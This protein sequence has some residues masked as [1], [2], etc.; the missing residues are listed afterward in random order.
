MNDKCVFQNREEYLKWCERIVMKIYYAKIAMNN[1]NIKDAIDEI[2]R[3]LW[4]REGEE[5]WGP[6]EKT[7]SREPG[8]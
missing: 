4:I 3:S 5:L 7:K 8:W 2:G 1:E 6:D